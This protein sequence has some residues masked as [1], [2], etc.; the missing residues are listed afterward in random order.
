MMHVAASTVADRLGG[1]GGPVLGAD[2]AFENRRKP[3]S[4]W[5]DAA[6]DRYGHVWPRVDPSFQIGGTETVFT[7][8]SCFARNIE[9]ALARLG[10]NVPMLQFSIPASEWTGRPAGVLNTFT[11]PNFRDTLR[12]TAGVHDAGGVVRDADCERYAVEAGGA[13]FIDAGLASQVPVAWE[14]LVSRRQEV[15]DCLRYAFCSDIVVMTPGYVECW[16]DTKT[17]AYMAGVLKLRKSIRD[18]GRFVFEVRSF[19]DCQA[20]LLAAIDVIRERRPDTRFLVTASPVPLAT[21]FT[22]QDIRIANSYSKAVVRAVCG[23]LPQ[24][25]SG[26]DYFPSYES[27]TLSRPRHVWMRDGIHIQGAFIDEI[28]GR[29]VA[30]YGGMPAPAPPRY[31]WHGVKRWLSEHLRPRNAARSWELQPGRRDAI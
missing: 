16:R 12:W 24:L 28:A 14:R 6:S 1:D 7:I 29:L 8:G 11:P 30:A 21:T 20:D 17:G 22:G 19:Q 5:E 3:C 31:W 10:C 23:S 26:I 27:V 25:R 2:A 13:R 18:R 9:T 4:R 15:Y